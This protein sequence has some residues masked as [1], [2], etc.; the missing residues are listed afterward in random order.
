M[1]NS[2]Y[3]ILAWFAILL[4]FNPC[5]SF[6]AILGD[7]NGDGVV[8]FK[9]VIILYAYYL[10]KPTTD[11]IA[12]KAQANEVY[13]LDVGNVVLIP[14]DN[15]D[16]L[17]GDGK[18]DFNDVIF[19]YTSYQAADTDKFN[20]PQLNALAK[21]IYSPIKGE[22]QNFPGLPISSGSAKIIIGPITPN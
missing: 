14:N 13:K 7:Y 18:F 16:D 11:P 22:I 19:L 10:S 15:T 8:N 1:K 20:G 12:I 17:N 5:V 4:I 21:E 6:G 2:K 3:F 9:D